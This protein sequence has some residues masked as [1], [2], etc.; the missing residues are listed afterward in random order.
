MHFINSLSATVMKAGALVC[1]S[2]AK[3]YTT[4]RRKDNSNDCRETVVTAHQS[5][6]EGL[7]DHFQARVALNVTADQYGFHRNPFLGNTLPFKR[8]K[9][10]GEGKNKEDK[11]K[12]R[13]MT[14]SHYVRNIMT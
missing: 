12:K 8:N 1:W 10:E 5:V 4:P 13:A 14:E 2:A 9:G 3:L 7:W 11:F 6:W